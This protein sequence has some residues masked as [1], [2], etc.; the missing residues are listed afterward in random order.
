MKCLSDLDVP[1]NQ[2]KSK[3]FMVPY[4]KNQYFVDRFNLLNQMFETFSTTTH[5]YH[6]RIAL[7]G[8]DSVGKTQTYVHAIFWISGVNQETL[9]TGFQPIALEARYVVDAGNLKSS[10]I[11]RDVLS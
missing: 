5:A 8:L 3:Y 7:Y 11:V 6:R 9:L 4:D 10:E 1:D 2:I